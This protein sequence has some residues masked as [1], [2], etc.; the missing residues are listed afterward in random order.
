MMCDLNAKKLFRRKLMVMFLGALQQMYEVQ[1]TG[2]VVWIA[3]CV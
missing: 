3:Q 2:L 1:I